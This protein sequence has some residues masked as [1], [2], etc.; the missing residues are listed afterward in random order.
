MTRRE[1]LEAACEL[2]VDAVGLVFV[3]GTPRHVDVARARELIRGLPPFVARVGVFA[4]EDPMRIRRIREE[5][6]LTAVQLHGSESPGHC[7]AVGGVR[8]KAFR[9]K[10]PWEPA[11]LGA[12]ECDACLLDYPVP[13]G[14]G[15]GGIAFEWGTLRGLGGRRII[16]AGGL[17]PENVP[18]AIRA[19][20]PYAVDVSTGIESAPGHKDRQRMA[21]FVQAVAECG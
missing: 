18:E 19:V 9:V 2:G 7:A 8:I 6:G 4:D 10:P 15:G 14:L 17:T 13:G 20:R 3:P 16:L 21:A 11:V 12:Y 5:L 1:D